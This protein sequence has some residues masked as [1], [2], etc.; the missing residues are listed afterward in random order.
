MSDI[1]CVTSRALCKGDFLKQLEK[2]AAAKPAGIILRE[3]DLSPGEY[4]ALAIQTME[5]CE[6]HGAPCI[7]HSFADVAAELGCR[8]IHLPLP[9][10]R[11]LSP[12][13]RAAFSEIGAS[14]H[15]AADA[16]EAEA[17]GCTY[18]TAGH[19]FDT[20]CKRGLPGR[21]LDF[22]R[23]VCKYA[24]IP[25]YAIGGVSPENISAVRAAGAAGAC[26]MSGLM[27]CENPKQ[28]LIQFRKGDM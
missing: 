20:D 17:L 2:I 19:V 15:S 18:I 13:K 26:I 10:L 4:R 24:S 12:E 8:A 27:R 16:A 3:K 9:I 5:I 25:V 28:Y 14:C 7:L 11:G 23:Q 22:L 21:G 1:L 6:S